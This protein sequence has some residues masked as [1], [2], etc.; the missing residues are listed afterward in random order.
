[1]IK[2]AKIDFKKGIACL[3][4]ASQIVMAAGCG[5]TK[6]TSD[7][8]S[9][10]VDSTM[11]EKIY[12]TANYQLIY[13]DGKIYLATSKK[14]WESKPNKGGVYYDQINYEY[15]DVT[16]GKFIG[17]VLAPV[18]NG[19]YIKGI[20]ITS[21]LDSKHYNGEYG[22]GKIIPSYCVIPLNTILP[23]TEFT[24]DEYD[25]LTSNNEDLHNFIKSNEVFDKEMVITSFEDYLF[26]DQ[27][28][29][30]EVSLCKYTC[31]DKNGEESIF[32]GYR[33]SYNEEDLGYNYI[34]DIITGS[35]KYIGE[36]KIDSYESVIE[37]ELDN[38]E[39]KS[40]LELEQE[41]DL[42]NSQERTI[43]R[44]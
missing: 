20:V 14:V 37:E 24:K 25:Y 8:Y 44:K 40:I 5:T 27:E 23:I 39:K 19:P 41:L 12:T 34:Y 17:K 10:N 13:L 42:N 26:F 6:Q 18:P 16:N 22:Y 38:S 31:L 36:F 1:M 35:I 29:F 15:Y 7:D 9:S 32:I 28:R 21:L 33:C 2:K 11:D 4:A 30:T 3:L 43:S